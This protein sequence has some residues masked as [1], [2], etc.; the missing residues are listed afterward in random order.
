MTT[1]KMYCIFLYLS[2]LF[3]W[4]T[5][6][7]PV[8]FFTE[9]FLDLGTISDTEIVK[10]ELTVHNQ[11]DKT[12]SVR[13]I[14]SC[15][16]IT[17]ENSELTIPPNSSS[18][19]PFEFHPKGYNGENYFQIFLT[20]TEERMTV[21]L[22]TIILSG[23]KQTQ[24][25]RSKSSFFYTENPSF[26][27][28]KASFHYFS[29]RNCKSCQ[30]LAKRVQKKYPNKKFYFYFLESKQNQDLFFEKLQTPDELSSSEPLFPEI[31]LLL[32][33]QKRYA[34]EKNIE[35]FVTGEKKE[36]SKQTINNISGPAIFISGLLDG[37]NPCAFTVIVLLL[38][39]M[40]LNFKKRGE[41][42]VAG[43]FYI[44]AVF[45]TYF[46][47]GLG[48]FEFFRKLD[49]FTYFQKIFKYALSIFLG[50]LA[51]LTLLDIIRY[52]Q[53][54][55]EKMILKLPAI[56]QKTI[57]ENIRSEMKNYRIFFSSILLGFLVSLLELVCTGQVYLPIVGYMTRATPFHGLFYLFVYNIGFIL[58][59]SAV[60]LFVY[61][62]ISSKKVGEWFGKNMLV[63][64][65]LFLILFLSFLI[66]N[67]FI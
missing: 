23:K 57:R 45:I 63:V 40:S 65:I 46:L 2:L 37:I 11:T 9:P 50:T 61:A 18:F 25:N 52:L 51:F 32:T 62:G 58:P 49:Q 12:L 6:L 5:S 34:G 48:L 56:L 27:E 14:V 38:S 21:E 7:F 54:K 47:V 43:I 24:K 19:L 4:K 53:G 26:L 17:I 55:N 3:C 60:F 10:K 15:S 41:I 20:S 33:E 22:K 67:I 44:T 8:S 29:Y 66:I 13:A 64:K 42:L 39:Y 59:L 16:C 30:K 35:H 31:P 28:D 36:V 1:K